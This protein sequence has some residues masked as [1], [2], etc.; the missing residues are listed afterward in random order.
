[1]AI[2]HSGGRTG[3]LDFNSATKAFSLVDLFR[4]G[5]LQSLR[6]MRIRRARLI[7]QRAIGL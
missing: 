5:S 6:G 2:S 3:G 1:M 4:H 7:R